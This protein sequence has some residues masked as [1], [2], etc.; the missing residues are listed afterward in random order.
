LG[1]SK[2]QA[3]HPKIR[4]VHV[5][6]AGEMYEA[7][8]DAFKS[9]DISVLA[10][11]VADFKPSFPADEKIKKKEDEFTLHL[12]KTSDILA[13]LGEIKQPW[14]TLVGFALET[15]NELANAKTKLEVKN[16]DMIVLN[17]LKDEGA[18]FGHDTNK[19][20]IIGREAEPVTLPLLSKVEAAAIIVDNILEFQY[21]KKTV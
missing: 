1:P 12:T 15:N 2:E 18:G 19:I 21:A 5:E 6:S 14:Q 16:A 3:L 17:S 13:S 4:T 9:A 11:A 10:A 20:T 8:I 7:A